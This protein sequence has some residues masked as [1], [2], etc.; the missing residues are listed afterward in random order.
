MGA[1][2]RGEARPVRHCVREKFAKRSWTL[3][4]G[5]AICAV[6]LAAGAQMRGAHAHGETARND[7]GEQSSDRHNKQDRLAAEPFA[8]LERE[9][10]S[11]QADLRLAVAQSNAW[12]A[13]ERGVRTIAEIN[14]EQQRRMMALAGDSGQHMSGAAFLAWLAETARTRS[15]ATTDLQRHFGALYDSLGEEQRQLID[16]RLMLSQTDPLGR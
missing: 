3:V 1:F 16:R 2:N 10:P 5:A 11:L 14:R 6:S 12:R 15:Q 8:A 9:L 4:A 7:R 13:F